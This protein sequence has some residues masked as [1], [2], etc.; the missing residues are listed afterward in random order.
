MNDNGSG[1]N[2]TLRLSQ[3]TSLSHIHYNYA[4]Y[5]LRDHWA[6]NFTVNP[7]SRRQIL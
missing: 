3:K 6:H 4:F 1:T 2:I 7:K 5:K